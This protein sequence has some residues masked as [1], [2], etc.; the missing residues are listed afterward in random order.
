MGARKRRQPEQTLFAFAEGRPERRKGVD[1]L[2]ASVPSFRRGRNLLLLLERMA[3]FRAYG[4]YNALLVALQR[5]KARCVL[6]SARWGNYNRE[7]KP[8]AAPIVL[9]RPFAPVVYVFDVADTR[10]IRGRADRLPVEWLVEIEPE[11]TSPVPEALVG[12]LLARLPW[13]GI[14]HETVPTGPASAGELYLAGVTDA[15]IPVFVRGGDVVG[16]RPAYVLGTR[17]D[18][19]PDDRFSALVGALARLFCHHLRCGYER[20]WEG[21]RE[22]TA[23]AETLEVDI[24]VW[25]VCRRRGVASP[26]YGQLAEY[27]STNEPLPEISLDIVLEAVAEVERMLGDCSVR[28][29]Y[30]YRFSPSFA[31]LAGR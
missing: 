8:G 22:L 2:F 15:E 28:D 7:V 31:A 27:L 6:S 9:L 17:E 10:V 29:G 3:R 5:P 16:W 11:P 1:E 18:V 20:G 26:A 13:W 4:P 24:V 19:R 21:G 12:R 23:R 14:R 30:L 25:L